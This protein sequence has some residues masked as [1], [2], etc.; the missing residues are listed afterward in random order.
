MPRRASTTRK[1]PYFTK[2][3]LEDE[4]NCL[5]HKYGEEHDR[6]VE[7]PVPIDDIVELHLGLTFEFK[8]MQALF[9]V[10][11]VHGALWVNDRIVG[12]DLSLDPHENPAMLGRYHFT[13]AHEVGHWQ[14][15]RH[16]YQ[17][18]ANQLSLLPEAEDRAE[19]VCRSS[20]KSPLEWQ[21]N[22]FA[23][24]LLM[25]PEMVRSVWRELH[26][27]LDPIYLEDLDKNRDAI[28]NE[29]SQRR[30]GYSVP[31]DR[32]PNILLEH[33]AL[34]LAEKF[35]VSAEA[36]RIRLEELGLLKR[37]KENLLF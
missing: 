8:D 4:A 34:P 16:L 20:D 18:R 29:E 19:Y 9:G 25:P 26:G 10:A 21:A 11:D 33:A 5:L 22:Y 30:G 17:S 7:P 31:E 12:V 6:V 35:Q 13:L 28:L 24:A 3:Q 2:Q 36:M 32:I 1:E 15:H 37:K 27:E 14:L 23:A